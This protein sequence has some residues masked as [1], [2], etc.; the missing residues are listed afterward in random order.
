MERLSVSSIFM[1]LK[2]F[3]RNAVQGDSD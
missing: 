3:G 2:K 1:A